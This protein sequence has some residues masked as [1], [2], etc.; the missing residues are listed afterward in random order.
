VSP[1]DIDEA[2][3]LLAA[4]RRRHHGPS[5]AGIAMTRALL[6]MH[7]I[8]IPG[9]LDRGFAAA[10]TR[11]L[12]GHE[13]ADWLEIPRSQLDGLPE[14]EAGMGLF[15]GLV[16]RFGRALLEREAFELAGY[17][18]APFDIPAELRT[19]WNLGE[20]RLPA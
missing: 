6:E 5:D 11:H 8:A 15:L 18:R 19:A 1:R 10:V 4:I 12:V 2:A 17:Q 20:A 3:E 16:D 13:I 14:H 7:D 9:H